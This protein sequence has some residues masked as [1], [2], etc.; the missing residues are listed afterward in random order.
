MVIDSASYLAFL[1]AMVRAGAWAAVVPPFNH[2][3]IPVPAR[4][5][6]AAGLALAV[7]PAL[8]RQLGTTVYDTPTLLGALAVQALAGAGLGMV[9]RILLLAVTSAGSMIDL[10]GG[11]TI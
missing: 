11:F 4:A 2:R 10:F 6:I 1:M 8:S 7:A 5:C 9:V 3:S